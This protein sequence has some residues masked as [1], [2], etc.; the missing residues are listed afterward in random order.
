MKH[1]VWFDWFLFFVVHKSY[2]LGPEVKRETLYE[3]IIDT[4]F[5]TV[6]ENIVVATI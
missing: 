3:A 6:T 4:I 1:S 2:R 5:I